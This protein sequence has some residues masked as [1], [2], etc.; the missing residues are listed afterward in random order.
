MLT[1]VLDIAPFE[2]KRE[3][4]KSQTL[5]VSL[6]VSWLTTTKILEGLRSE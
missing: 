5:I 1:V 2:D 3:L 4:P 6:L